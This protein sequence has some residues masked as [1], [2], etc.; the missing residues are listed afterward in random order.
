MHGV[1]G[2]WVVDA[3][4]FPATLGVNPQHSIMAIAMLL[5]ERI[6]GGIV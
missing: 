6:S 2:V 3:S 4:I 5:A 1:R